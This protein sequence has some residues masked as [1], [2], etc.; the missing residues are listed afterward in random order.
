MVTNVHDLLKEFEDKGVPFARELIPNYPDTG[1]GTKGKMRLI[2]LHGLIESAKSRELE[3]YV[4]DYLTPQPSAH[5]S[6]AWRG[7][8]LVQVR[9]PPV[10]IERLTLDLLFLQATAEVTH[11]DPTRYPSAPNRYEINLTAEIIDRGRRHPHAL[12]YS[13]IPETSEL[14]RLCHRSDLEGLIVEQNPREA[15]LQAIVVASTHSQGWKPAYTLLGRPVC[16][17]C[18]TWMDP[19]VYDEGEYQYCASCAKAICAK[20]AHRIPELGNEYLLFCSKKCVEFYDAHQEYRARKKREAQ[21][22]KQ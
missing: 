14:A 2:G 22:E 10:K 4:R 17:Q 8:K 6:Y 7:T 13:Q 20:C 19:D 21:E 12:N 16:Y 11:V 3:V 9:L 1:I 15:I 5:S 18:R